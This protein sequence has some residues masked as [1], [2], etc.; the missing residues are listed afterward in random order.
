[1]Q[2]AGEKS[3]TNATHLVV[4]D[5]D[6]PLCGQFLRQEHLDGSTPGRGRKF[7]FGMG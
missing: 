6:H 7:T 5:E 2:A 1:M 3:W 4:T